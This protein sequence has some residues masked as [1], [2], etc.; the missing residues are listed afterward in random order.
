MLPAEQWLLAEAIRRHRLFSLPAVIR[1]ALA[2][3]GEYVPP[4]EETRL[5]QD[6]DASAV[7]LVPDGDRY[8]RRDGGP[9]LGRG[10]LGRF[11]EPDNPQRLTRCAVRCGADA[12]AGWYRRGGA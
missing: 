6:T 7:D 5:Q 8:V 4:E 11:T 12:R 2:A 10:P 3:A 1:H 9:L